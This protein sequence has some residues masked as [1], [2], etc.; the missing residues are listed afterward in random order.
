MWMNNT[1]PCDCI[2]RKGI[3][4]HFTGSKPKKKGDILLPYHYVAPSIVL[5]RVVE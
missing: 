4:T 1:T 5:H 2:P 3:G